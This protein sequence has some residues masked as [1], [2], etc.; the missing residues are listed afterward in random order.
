VKSW[1]AAVRDTF[2]VASTQYES[3]AVIQQQSAHCLAL[4]ISNEIPKEAIRTCID[5]GAGTG[6]L[7]RALLRHYPDLQIT[8]NDIALSMIEQGVAPDSN[9]SQPLSQTLLGDLEDLDSH[10]S[11]D[12]VA[13]NFA[14]QWLERPREALQRWTKKGKWIALS[15]PIDGSFPEWKSLHDLIG[16]PSRL[17]PLP[18]LD[19]ITDWAKST[20]VSHFTLQEKIFQQNVSSPLEFAR[21]LKAT[22]ASLSDADESP[23]TLLRLE[24]AFPD[25]LTITWK[26]V[27]LFIQV[28]N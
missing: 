22:G 10:Q 16:L 27:F 3:A 21:H 1:K 23:S 17:R 9:S 14:W 20:G 2:A 19:E 7:S 26:V 5:L 24:R 4:L 15:L 8:L 6:L 11:W 12:L 25:P 28:R 18:T 13:S